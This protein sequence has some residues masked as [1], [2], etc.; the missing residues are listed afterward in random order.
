MVTFFRGY[1]N[2]KPSPKR[3]PQSVH[4]GRQSAAGFLYPRS[5]LGAAQSRGTF[6]P[7][8]LLKFDYLLSRR[9]CYAKSS[10]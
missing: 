1:G 5:P 3:F 8:A 2:I 7:Q 6:I 10:I 9:L 4:D